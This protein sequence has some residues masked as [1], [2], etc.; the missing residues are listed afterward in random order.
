[1]DDVDPDN[2]SVLSNDSDDPRRT[3]RYQHLPPSPHVLHLPQPKKWLD[4]DTNNRSL[5][6]F[7][8]RTT[9]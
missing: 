5:D 9:F 2:S 8:R 3:V 7:A 1:M 4:V 6:Q